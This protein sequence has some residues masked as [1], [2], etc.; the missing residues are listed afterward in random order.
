MRDASGRF[1]AEPLRK[2][3][4]FCLMHTILFP[5][6]PA[7]ACEAIVAYID[8]ET[9]S[10]DVLSGRILEVGA[11]VDGSRAMFSTVVHPGCDA[12]LD[13]AS[14]HGIPHE[15]LLRGPKF[16]EAFARLDQFLQ[17]AS[18]SVLD[19]DDD[20]EDGRS[21]AA[22]KQDLEVCL[23]AHNGAKFDFPFML[24]ECLR[25]GIAPAAMLSWVY[26]DTLDVVRAT[27]GAG[28]CAKLQCALRVCCGPPTL[29]AHRAL[30]DCVALEAVVRHLS[31]SLGIRPWELLRPFAF[32]L[33][34][35][36][37]VAQMTALIA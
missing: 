14:V 26:V 24:Q 3:G 27:D 21:P 2:G 5:M 30:D 11:L 17:Y 22:M 7:K 23:V 35:A 25:A 9:N 15:E 31:A 33:D 29:R 36:S 34:G 1:V 16:G 19:S 32:R 28:E 10:L 37:A 12:H 8:L 18:L 13:E 4:S 20:S 6:E